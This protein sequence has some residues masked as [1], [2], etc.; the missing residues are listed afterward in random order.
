MLTVIVLVLVAAGA[1]FGTLY[2]MQKNAT[3]AVS[4]QLNAKD[5][6]LTA[7]Q[8][9]Q[10]ATQSQLNAAQNENNNLTTLN[11]SLTLLN[12]ADTA[13]VTAAKAVE[14]ALLAANG[15]TITVPAAFEAACR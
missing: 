2:F 15:N 13:C 9:Q 14:A 6:A 5:A 8:A 4:R 3:A 11:K 1:T 10:R 7:A 12:A